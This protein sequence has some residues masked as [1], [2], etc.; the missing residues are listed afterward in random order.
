[1][2]KAVKGRRSYSSTVRAEQAAQTR[3][4]ILQAAG[5]RFEADGYAR[6]TVRAIAAAAGVAADTVYAVFGT[7]ARILT[8]LIDQRLAPAGEANVMDRPQAQAVHDEPDP[9]RQLHRFA[10]DMTEVVERVRPIYEV[11]QTAAAVDPEMAGILAEMDG[12]R[13]GNMRR[14]AG[15]MAERGPLRVNV[16]RAAEILWVL[17][18]PDMARLLRDGRGW[19][20]QQHAAWLEDTLA[21]TLL[22]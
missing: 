2:G 21:R 6:T 18:S 16:D 9:R 20:R 10:A 22:P 14:V 17:A 4:R 15:W 12:Y 1:M 11:L 7:K 5:S 13:L 3:A 8:A 19:T